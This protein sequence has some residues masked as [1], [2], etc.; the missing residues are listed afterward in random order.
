MDYTALLMSPTIITQL[1]SAHVYLRLPKGMT[2]QSIPTALLEDLGQL[3]KANSIE[4]NK[5]KNITIIYTP[6]SNI[7]VCSEVHIC[8]CGLTSVSLARDLQKTGDMA[9][10]SVMF[11]NDRVVR[12]HLVRDR[13][14]V[15]VNR[16]NK[17]KKEVAVDHE[18]VRQER[19]RALGREKKLNATKERNERLLVERQREADRVARD[20]SS[21]EFCRVRRL[22]KLSE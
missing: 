7:K 22:S 5:K 10:G 8:E 11:H 19:E 14:N 1:S 4:G 3:T 2:W 15:I 20:Y 16:L 6:W 18:A 17:T 13:E 12:R 21:G 9:T